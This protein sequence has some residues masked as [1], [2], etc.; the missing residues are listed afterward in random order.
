MQKADEMP[1][2][3]VGAGSG[4]ASCQVHLGLGV[5]R[6]GEERTEGRRGLRVSSRVI[7]IRA[8]GGAGQKGSRGADCLKA[9]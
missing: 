9:Q 8:L 5:D 2:E 1:R 4:K 3:T 6:R 7:K